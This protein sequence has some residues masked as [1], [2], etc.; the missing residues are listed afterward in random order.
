MKSKILYIV[1]FLLAPLP[2]LFGQYNNEWIDYNKT[3]Y[4]FKIETEGIYRISQ[5][6]LN[7][8]GLG[9]TDAAQFQLWKNGQQVPIFTSKPSG[10]FGNGDFI[11]FYGTP[12]DGHADE[13][14][15]R[16]PADHLKDARSLFTDSAAYFLTI[17]S[18]LPNLR[19]NNI[20]NTAAGSS[21][22]PLSYIWKTV[23]YDY[24][25]IYDN[26]LTNYVHRGAYDNSTG[27]PVYSSLFTAG[28]MLSSNEFHRPGAG[29]AYSNSSAVFQ[30]LLPAT[31][32]GQNAKLK[33]SVAGAAPGTRNYS[34]FLNNTKLWEHSLQRFQLRYDSAVNINPSVLSGNSVTLHI[35][36]ADNGVPT[37]RM[38]AGF[39]ILE[40]P[41]QPNAGNEG[42][43]TFALPASS[44][45][46]LVRMANVAAN[47]GTP[48]LYDLTSNVRM[49][50]LSNS[51]GSV[52]FVIGPAPSGRELVLFVNNHP[53][54]QEVGQLQ[55]RQFVNYST[56]ANQGDYLIVTHP[57]FMTGSNQ[58]AEAYRQYRASA[59][60]G[61]FNSKSYSID[62]L[63][64]Q[65]AYGIKNHPLSI[66]NFLRFARAKF[67]VFPQYCFLIG[68]GVNYNEYRAL[69]NHPNAD[70]LQ[71]VPT[72]GEP[73]SDIL[74][75]SEDLTSNVNTLIGRLSVL[76]DEEI[77][78]YLEKMKLYEAHQ[79]NASQTQEA[80]AWMK[81]VIHVVGAN[82]ASLE[83]IL[84]S[85]ME[86]YEEVI[87]DTLFGGM[88]TTFNKSN[89][90][91]ASVI[92]DELM[93]Q[94]F[95]EG[96]SLL[97]YFGHSSATALDYNLD[98][99]HQY[100][101]PDKFPVFLLN[102]CNA[103]NFFTFDSLRLHLLNTISEKYVLA[104]NRGAIAM[105]AS[106]H[107]GIVSGLHDY[108]TGFYD[109][110]AWKSYNE[111]I[112]ANM[113]DAINYHNSLRNRAPFI[114][115]NHTMQQT[116]HGDP[117]LKINAFEKP[118]YSIEAQ[119]IKVEPAFISIAE[120][121]FTTRIRYYNIG[122]A[123]N[124]SIVIRISRKYPNSTTYPSGFMETVFEQKVKAPYSI[125][126]ID[127]S[128]PIISERDKGTNVIT[129]MLDAENEVDELSETNNE[130]SR[131]VVIYEDEIRPVYPYN[132][133]II[134]KSTSKV[135][136][137]TSDPFGEMNN[138][139]MEMDTTALFNSPL[140]VTRDVNATGGLIE[141]DPGIT[142]V[143]NRVYYWRVAII[144]SGEE[145]R[146][147]QSSFVYLNGPQTGFNQS[148]LYQHTASLPTHIYMD[149][150]DRRWHFSVR[151]LNVFVNHSIYGVSG[152]TDSDFSVNLDNT[153][154]IASACVGHSLIFNVFDGLSFKPWL[155]Y[156]GGRFN[157][158][159]NNCEGPNDRKRQYNFEFSDMTAE[160]RRNIVN[161][162]DAIPEGNYIMVRKVMDRPF[163][164]ETF[165]DT[166]KSDEQAFGAGN[167]IYHRLKDAGF[168]S[169][170]SFN[171]PRIFIFLYK[172]GD[173]GF[174]PVLRMSEGLYDRVQMNQNIPVPDSAARI[175]S[176]VF[177]PAKAWRE[178][179]WNGHS[180][181]NTGGDHVVL[182]LVG[183][184]RSGTETV[185][186]TLQANQKTLNISN[187]NANQYPFLKLVMR[188]ADS[189]HYTPY[190]LDW[191]QLYYTPVP[192]GALAPNIL[193]EMADTLTPGQ[194]LALKI[195]FKNI[196]DASFDSILVKGFILD[197]NNVSHPF[198]LPRFKPLSPQDTIT[199]ILSES[200]SNFT[201]NNTLYL[202]V[203]PDNDQPEQ[204]FFN[205][206]LY[207]TFR[208]AGDNT[209]PVM[210]VTFD[211]IRIMDK[212]IVSAK[213]H[214]Q[215]KLE[216]E[217]RLLLLNNPEDVVIKLRYPG[218]STYREYLWNTD[219]L[220]FNPATNGAEGNIALV[221]FFPDLMMDTQDGEYELVISAR[222]RS[223][224][225][226]GNMDYKVTFQVYN[227][228][229]ISNLL[230][231]PNPFST[232]TAF[233]FT[234][235]GSKV[236][237]EFKIQIFTVTGKIVREI[238]RQELGNIHV[239][240]NITEYKWDGT[241]TYGQ[242]L[243][244]GVYLYRLVT[245]LDG[246]A[247]DQFRLNDGLNQN[248]ADV[249][250][251]FFNKG[252]GKMVIL[253]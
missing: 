175:T 77:G 216:D 208:V 96:F 1:F 245:S 189:V 215:I 219:T 247:I 207:K 194:P 109:A 210:D 134:N 227:K 242:Q 164:N 81:N 231:Y 9:S 156:P 84:S 222:D 26:R 162:L 51:D 65:F 43:F 238:T 62:Q 58:N 90:G 136:G 89:T 55:K 122:K 203:N 148:H 158:G 71:L 14:L 104:K 127:I 179:R 196:S 160:S 39:A 141:F 221:D 161:F 146:W 97:T 56:A 4:K 226:A 78:T 182:H 93:K 243:A 152:F 37:D 214:I 42:F 120:S 91:T 18:S 244:N 230:N 48:F 80:K 32:S 151:P 205:N 171:R 17:N 195:A 105:I 12:N 202:A 121:N 94:K 173:A 72:F 246:N 187:I 73:G 232:S 229:M 140:K 125:D 239:G 8:A 27:E 218:E 76:E 128:L 29:S 174:T 52:S 220:R 223:G 114:V 28:E 19:I 38:V 180:E 61:G 107:L 184:N 115:E 142:Y 22:T 204:H 159:M 2:L 54:V 236:P 67:S 217:N 49:E 35:T 30:N 88:V 135:Y 112:G 117:A 198:T 57:K 237:E 139:R 206:F 192:E 50:G 126:S 209:N 25:G 132:Y 92:S 138:Y 106:T 130:V 11:E 98:D 110:V 186:R 235:T 64:D 118:D 99:P 200:S 201:G 101:N 87:E 144:K 188:N 116:L 83:T 250:D 155:N 124:D 24:Q 82:D 123:I 170:D 234:L 79:Q 240:T 69:E 95:E 5:A 169:I 66:K 31:A 131:D 172:K 165:A 211:G 13:P 10:T 20:N 228:P 199:V 15:F 233:V 167:T 129:V 40:Y 3:Y 44:E 176:P 23:R 163:E 197:K 190:Q 253:R 60:G 157:S 111:S 241:D 252:Y 7:A 70:Q 36:K 153:Q 75:A 143:E 147:N 16:N 102:G 185:L 53:R 45:N 224:N 150:T 100:N 145:P 34:V 21:L 133:A 191:W 63:E 248:Q 178:V 193:F 177:G 251:H 213:P 168:A 47:G 68:K 6:T 103:G 41:R 183:I 46:S 225:A 119:N 108:S 181:D 113:Q 212:D 137:S 154:A 149:S 74:L 166:W 59:A 33:L 85:Y 249:T 86:Q